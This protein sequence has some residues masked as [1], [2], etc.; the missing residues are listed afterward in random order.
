M[1]VFKN[2]GNGEKYQTFSILKEEKFEQSLKRYEQSLCIHHSP[3]IFGT[4]GK[5]V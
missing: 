5:A 2:I 4:V 1:Y 3:K